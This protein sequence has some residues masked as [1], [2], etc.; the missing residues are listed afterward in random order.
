VKSDYTIDRV[1]KS[2]AAE[3]LLRFHY[4]K[5]ISK[6]FKSG[7]NY[8][9]YKNNEFCPLN[10]G[11]IQGVCIFTGL[12]VPEIAKGAFGLERHEQQGLFELSR[13]CIHPNT[14]Q[15]EYNITSWFVSKAIRCLRKETNVRGI[16]S[17]ADSDHHAGTIYRAC[18]FQYCGLSEPKKDFYFADGTKHSR[19]SVRGSEG[20]WRERSRKHRYVMVFD[21]KLD[22]LW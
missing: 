10:I 3:L 2:E 18:N 9:L 13:L 22:L 6:T 15:S 19:G 7:Y 17:Y 1:T 12:P 14:Q 8:G 4:L 20:E 16:I 21:K 11:G 5:D